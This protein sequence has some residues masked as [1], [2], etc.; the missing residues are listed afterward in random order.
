MQVIKRNGTVEG[1][2]VKKVTK[3]ITDCAKGLNTNTSQIIQKVINGIYNKVKTTELDQLAIETAAALISKHPDYDK[4]A[5]R[6]ALSDLH[7]ST[8]KTFSDYIQELT[9]YVHPHTGASSNIAPLVVELARKNSDRIQAVIDQNSSDNDFLTYFGLATLKESYLLKCGTRIV[10]RPSY[11]YMRVSLSVHSDDIRVAFQMYNSMMQKKYIHA[12]PTLF[13]SGT[14][15]QQLSSCFL[16]N[17]EDSLSSI[18]KTFTDCAMISKHA[19]GIGLNIHDIRSK[20]SY[21]AKTNGK[22]NGIVPMLRVLNEITQYVDQSNKRPGRAAVYLEPHHAEILDFLQLRRNAGVE[23]QKTRELFTA[24]WVSD[25]FMKR[26]E[27]DEMFSLFCPKDAP[28]LSE[29]YGEDFEEKYIQYENEGKARSVMRAR[30]IWAAAIASQIETGTPYILF[31]D[32]VNEKNNQKNVGVIKS[33]NLCAEIVEYTSPDEIAV[34]NLASINASYFYDTRTKKYDYAGLIDTAAE[35]C[36]NLNKI[37]DQN[38]YPVPETSRSNLKH[39]PLGLGLQ[40]LSDLFF[41]MKIPFESQSAL[42]IYAEI[43]ECIYYGAMK[44]SNQQAQLYGTYE[45]YIG[46]PISKGEYQFDMWHV[47][48]EKLFL[49]EKWTE[50]Q[51]M[52]EQYGIR[53]SLM[54]C[55]QPT[56]GTSNIMGLCES[57]EPLTSNLY[58]RTTKSGEFVILN[59]Y[60]VEDLENLKLWNEKTINHLIT[61]EGSVQQMDISQEMKDIY[62]TVWEIKQKHVIDM[63]KVRSA[64]TCQSQSMNLFLRAP[65]QNQVSSMLFYAWKMGLKTGMYYLRT[66]PAASATKFV[67]KVGENFVEQTKTKSCRRGDANSPD[68]VSCSG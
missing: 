34:C 45:S 42:Q 41:K 4:L 35:V 49:R 12:S 62:K 53:N 16:L 28:G 27:K 25:L 9:D 57:V 56:A 13:N 22:S 65:T 64:F 21:I 32:S 63:A 60:L 11:M 6:I 2:D 37:I 58:S 50:L 7:K 55:Q 1:L 33:S 18:F 19:G 14:L 29:L 47:P 15:S 40:G 51:P 3:R 39:R 8:P 61:H 23:S 52:I 24:L 54:I 68:C 44:S 20:G 36:V 10:E 43:A 26:V 46:S 5:V 31:K 38:H 30:D 48:R 17:T 67:D 59:K 66:Q